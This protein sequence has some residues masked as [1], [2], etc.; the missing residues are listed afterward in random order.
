MAIK[1]SESA[2]EVANGLSVK[3]AE[4]EWM[5]MAIIVTLTYL[6]PKSQLLWTAHNKKTSIKTIKNKDTQWQ[7]Q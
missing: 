1:F 7:A 2:T 6:P 4:T 3:N 5:T